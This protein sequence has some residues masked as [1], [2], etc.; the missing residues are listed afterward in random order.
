M[1]DEIIDEINCCWKWIKYN[2]RVNC[3]PHWAGLRS[4][5]I[6]REMF[7]R[8]LPMKQAPARLAT[9]AID[10]RDWICTFGV[11]RVEYANAEETN[12]IALT[13]KSLDSCNSRFWDKNDR[14]QHVST[15]W[16]F[17]IFCVS[18]WWAFGDD[19]CICSAVVAIK[20]IPEPARLDWV[21]PNI[22]S[23]LVCTRLW[24]NLTIYSVRSCTANLSLMLS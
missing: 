13:M 17:E 22:D 5:K 18:I 8:S 21:P 16:S 19:L 6:G 20:S 24:Y 15:R 7:V 2:Q 10:A 3:R 1:I 23:T 12:M 4:S 14:N 9:I 11:S